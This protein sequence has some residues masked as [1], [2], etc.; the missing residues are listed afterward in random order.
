MSNRTVLMISYWYPPTPGAGAQR[1]AGFARHLAEYGWQPL[2]VTAKDRGASLSAR[3]FGFGGDESSEGPVRVVRVPD[4][5]GAESVFVDYAGPPPERR[6]SLMRRMVFPDRFLIW[7]ARA[8]R[9][10]RQLTQDQMPSIVWTSFPPASAAMVGG[11]LAR[12]LGL[13]LV[14]DLRD[15]WMG[16]G[17]YM[18]RS[19][20]L[21][22]GLTELERRLVRQAA[23]VVTIS[24]AM[25]D[26]ICRRHD[27]PRDRVCTITNGFDLSRCVRVSGFEPPSPPEL[28]HVGSVSQRNRPD[29]FL[30][31]LASET[32]RAPFDGIVS[33]VGNLSSSYVHRLG[34]SGIV[35][36][37]RMVS[38]EEAWKQ[39]CRA[40]ALL[41]LVGDY[42]GTWGHN[43]K[44]FEY[45]RSGRPILCLEEMPGSNDRRLLE[46]LAAERTV[47]RSLNDSAGMVDGIREVLRL[48]TRIPFGQREGGGELDRYD[49]RRLA[50]ELADVLNR[51]LAGAAPPASP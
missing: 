50:G 47:F 15:P 7:A 39:T 40:T 43:T 34:L 33:F 42:V 44:L 13:P 8:T 21:N 12:A 45:L 20:R 41:L 32:R 31:A 29:L 17:G 30:N 5:V 24:D 35:R 26:D 2:V 23:V 48:G 10:A 46:E 51:C 37:S 25:T 38:W 19:T 28:V 36:T 4:L 1:A 3:L 22:A 14:L 16:A 49:R 27:V 18:P 11:D 6:E 9:E